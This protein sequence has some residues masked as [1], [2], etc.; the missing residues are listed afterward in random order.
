MIYVKKVKLSKSVL[1]HT[2]EFIQSKH[3]KGYLKKPAPM[4]QVFLNTKCI[5]LIRTLLIHDVRLKNTFKKSNLGTND[6]M[7]SNANIL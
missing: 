5:A 3:S 4:L 7:P 6:L 2:Y 1:C